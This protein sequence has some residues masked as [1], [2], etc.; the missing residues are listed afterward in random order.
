VNVNRRSISSRPRPRRAVTFVAMLSGVALVAGCGGTRVVTQAADGTGAQAAQSGVAA[1]APGTVPGAAVPGGAS[2]GPGGAA[3]A[4]PGAVANDA[5]GAAAVPAGSSGAV[6]AP[7]GS[8]GAVAVP[9]GS[10]S[11]AAASRSKVDKAGATRTTASKAAP[12]KAA[13]GG[14]GGGA[15]TGSAALV[16]NSRIF[17]GT[18]PCAPATGSP[19]TL[20]NVSTLSGVLGQLFSPVVPA[21]QTFV[22]SQNACGGLNGHPINLVVGDDQGDPSTAVTV[23]QNQIK[24]S[25]I[26]A[27]VGNIQVLTIDGMLSVVRKS[28]IPII[29]G[30]LTNNTWFSNPLLFPQGSPPQA[31][32]YGYLQAATEKFKKKKVGN[33][34]CLE[35]PQACTQINKAFVE[36]APKFGAE[37]VYTAQVSITSPDY[38]SQ[39]LAAKAAGVEVMA[40]TND[41][42]TQ[43][44]FANSCAKVGFKPQYVMYPLGVGNE[45]QF[46]G[47]PNLGGSYVPMNHFPW[48]GSDTPALKY[49]QDSIRRYNPGFTSGGA[50]SL[51]WAAGALLVA[52]SSRLT[53]APTTQQFLDA[54]YEFK[55]QKF[56]TL[57]GLTAPLTFVKGGTP[58]IPYCLFGATS[59]ADNKGWAAYSS[60]PTC[61]KEL[62]PSDPQ[63]RA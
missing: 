26:L 44:R 50:A 62:A 14:A 8:S 19:I 29:G 33:V 51:G 10:S 43:N 24:N 45:G 27:F 47:N 32:S 11:A 28:G 49:W 60:K 42:P 25:K 18:A 1:A 53:E 38:T 37:A 5:S 30:D 9:V 12:G 13:P 16:A 36:L 4:V 31:I 46:L 48:M 23:A 22:K 6:A 17:G 63:N 35:V 56:T 39:C 52:A 58:K 54:L 55:G 61:T 34:Y 7:R 2:A 21:L 3:V 40:I 20:G 57:G 15:A 59:T 41:A